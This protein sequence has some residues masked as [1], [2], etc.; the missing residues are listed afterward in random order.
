MTDWE[1]VLDGLIEG[2][3]LFF[4]FMVLLCGMFVLLWAVAT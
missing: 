3:A 1:R 2:A 4:G